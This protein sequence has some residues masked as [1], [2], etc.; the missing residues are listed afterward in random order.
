MQFKDIVGQRVLINR[1]SAVID[2]GRVSHA[3]M[4]QGSMGYGTLAIAVAY[5]QYLMCEH[6]QHFDNGSELRADSCGECPNCKKIQAMMHPDVHFYFPTTTTSRVK[7][8]PSASQF[9]DEFH[10]FL[11]DNKMYATMND[12]YDQSGAENKQGVYR[13]LDAEEMIQS[14]AMKSYEGGMK[15]FLLWMP[16]F[17]GPTVSNELL[18][19][20]EEPYENTLIMLAGENSN[21]L[22]PTVRSRVQ[23]T[24][25]PRISDAGLPDE[26]EG[27]YII[28]RRLADNFQDLDELKHKFVDWMRL[29]FKLNMEPLG[30]WVDDIST[31]GRERQKVFLKYAMDTVG[32]C[33]SQTSGAL[34]ANLKTGDERFDTMFPNMVTVRNVANIYEALNEAYRSV[35]RNA[36][37]KVLFMNLSFQLSRHIKNR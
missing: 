32:R 27:D 11:L 30:K 29:L 33:F 34:P 31:I 7:K 8:D 19:L 10:Q 37:P 24:K 6:R 20:L 17:M 25:V 9:R 15:V 2:S 26:V 28:A 4:M 5:V 22:I 14:M 1:L 23:I 18:K 3:Q 12:W 13:A 35:V 36:N 21:A 16:E